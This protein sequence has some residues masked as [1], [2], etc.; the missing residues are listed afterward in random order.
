MFSAL[1]FWRKKNREEKDTSIRGPY[2]WASEVPE[3]DT[4]VEQRYQGMIRAL[5]PDQRLRGATLM[6]ERERS[7]LSA[8]VH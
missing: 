2:R 4:E 3:D 7:R 8:A 6:T 5:N 1:A